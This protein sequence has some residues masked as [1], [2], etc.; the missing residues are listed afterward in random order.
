VRQR[1]SRLG[2]PV[3][4]MIRDDLKSND[5]RRAANAPHLKVSLEHVDQI[6][7]HLTKH[8]ISMYRLSSDLAPY[9]THPD[10]PQFHGIVAESKAELAALGAKA[11]VCGAGS[12]GSVVAARL[13]E[14]G[15]AS[16]VLL[17]AGGDDAA[18]AV[19]NPAQ[20]PLN[21][22]SSREGVLLDNQHLAWMVGVFPLAWARGSAAA[23]LSTSWCGREVVRATG[24]ILPLNPAM[25]LGAI[26]RSLAITAGSKIGAALLIQRVAG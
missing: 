8:Q 6:L 4:V 26:S 13:A 12:G 1:V 25:T 7:D 10:M 17:E 24:T 23:R 2:F 19:T 14:D 9:A 15:A 21:L 18:E 20:W 3:K 22:G 16:V 11:I 5:A